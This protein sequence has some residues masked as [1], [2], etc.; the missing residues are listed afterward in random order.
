[1]K[2]VSSGKALHSSEYHTKKQ[3]E[4]H[5]SQI[6]IILGILVVVII[7]ILILR[8]E[9][10][11]IEEIKVVG[12]LILR[13][14][15]VSIITNKVLGENYLWLIPKSNTLIYPRRALTRTLLTELPRI[16][17]LKFKLLSFHVL[18]ITVEERVPVALYC[19][20]LNK[21]EETS[22]CYFLDSNGYIFSRAPSF[23][24]E[25]YFI[26]SDGQDAENSK[27]REFLPPEKFIP[28]SNFI[29]IL[30]T[31][32]IHSTALEVTPQT[33]EKKSRYLLHLANFAVIYWYP[34]ENLDLIESSIRTL[35]TSDIL[36]GGDNFLDNIVYLDLTLPNKPYWLP[37]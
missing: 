20:D 3:K 13:S 11:Q 19:G 23:S 1:M 4:K 32:N 30:E 18:E 28:L 5:L 2:I 24:G 10:F 12:N 31:L 6:L 37:K 16:Q 26:Y 8:M 21:L 29:N 27:G 15:E 7:P 36:Q 14:E 22:D 9:R 33:L 25:V 35:I 17:T 34:E